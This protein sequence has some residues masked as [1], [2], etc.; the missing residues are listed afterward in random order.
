MGSWFQRTVVEGGRVPLLV[1]FA[2]FVITFITTRTVT[3]L[4]RSGRGPFK[5]NVSAGGLHIHHAVPGILLLV[6]GAFLAI[7]V[8]VD[9]RISIFAALCVGVG[10][11]LVLD[12]FALILHLQDV[13][14][15][16]EGRISV[17][18][19]SLAVACLGLLLVG[20][21]PFEIINEEDPSSA[22]A[23]T[24][25]TVVLHLTF[26]VVCMLKAK[27]KMALFG[28]FIPFLA[29]FGACRLAR[30]TSRWARRYSPQK[31]DRAVTR[32]ARYDARW[33]PVA[34]WISDVV[35]GKPSQPDPTPAANESAPSSST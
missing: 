7:G 34:D 22:V 30:P 23:S 1:C 8:D 32:A 24:V 17:E 33:D 14:W 9:S 29:A 10:T 28:T 31:L 16:D 18:I 3:R 19:V 13:Y 25:I 15:S 12:E 27:Y 6:A 35:A 11:S 2:A 20:A 5:N 21:N 4:I 26:I